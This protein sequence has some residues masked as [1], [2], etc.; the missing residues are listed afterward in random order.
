MIIKQGTNFLKESEK[1][2]L[3]LDL[4]IKQVNFL[5][6]RVYKRGED[7]FYPSVTSILQYMPKGKFFEN[8]LKDMGSEA[9]HIVKKASKEGTQTHNLI[10]QLIKGEEVEW[11]DQ[12]GNAKYSEQVWRM[13]MRFV[14]FW[15]QVK[16]EP[17]SVEEFVYSDKLEYAG[18]ADF[19]CKIDGEVWMID[20]KTSNG[21]YRT[22]DMQLSSYAKAWEEM[23]KG[24]IDRSGILWLKSPK[25]KPSSKKGVYQGGNWELKVIDKIDENFDL[26]LTI[27][28]LYKLDHPKVQPIYRQYPTILKL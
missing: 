23:G 14:E 28:K 21:L 10:E 19:I 16:P 20:F 13:A 26:F 9:D 18:T 3:N 27:Y 22:Y 2:R 24:K 12:Y 17:I 4:E 6:Q 8:W 15:K 7:R 11:M 1:N 5:D 25:R